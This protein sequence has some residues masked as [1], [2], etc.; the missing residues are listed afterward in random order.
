M[1]KGAFLIEAHLRTGRPIGELAAAHG[2]SRGWLYKLRARYS[3]EGPAGLA[4]RSR[5]PHHCPARIA[6]QWEEQII[7]L[8]KELLAAGFDAGAATIHHHLA[9]RHQNPPS[10][11]TIWR[12]LKARGFVTPQPHK[13]PKSSWQRFTAEFPSECWQADVTP[14]RWR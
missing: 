5:R 1:D 3:R 2:V 13:R 8:R 11:S 7:A 6:G 9:Q 4:P 12:I 14:R 10:V